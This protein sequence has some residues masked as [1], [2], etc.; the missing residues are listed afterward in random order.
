MLADSED[1]KKL[2]EQI[3]SFSQHNYEKGMLPDLSNINMGALQKQQKNSY[4]A[5][6]KRLISNCKITGNFDQ[7]ES[8]LEE[9][10]KNYID[11][12]F[13]VSLDTMFNILH[14]YQMEETMSIIEIPLQ[15]FLLYAELIKQVYFYIQETYIKKQFDNI[16]IAFIHEF[17]EY[18]LELLTSIGTLLLGKNYNS[19]IS[20]YRTFYENYIVFSYLENHSELQLR[21]IDH[22]KLDEL[23]L[24]IE[25]AKFKKEDSSEL[26]NQYQKL[27]S[28]YEKGF[29]QDYGWAKDLIGKNKKLRKM[30]SES[31][32]GDDFTYFYNLSCEYT[33]ATAF[34][35]T[36]RANF[37]NT[38]GFLMQISE[39]FSKEFQTLFKVLQFKNNKEK[40]LLRH[41]INVASKNFSEVI[42]KWYDL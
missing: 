28:N 26:E 31:N 16:E 3:R 7:C 33:H 36:N 2:G 23:S 15:S 22:A 5:D 21:F 18:S 12:K 37:E 17:I 29:E 27:L 11:E 34:S 25:L 4:L 32:L 20:I 8:E 39:I 6:I 24:R 10:T 38:I 13:P 9:Y 1:F 19:V 35:L 41:W 14:S 40:N 30:F 42:K